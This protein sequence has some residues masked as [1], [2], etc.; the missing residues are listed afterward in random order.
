MPTERLKGE[1]MTGKGIDHLYATIARPAPHKA[2]IRSRN[3]PLVLA[4]SLLYLNK[5]KAYKSNLD[6]HLYAF[7]R[8]FINRNYR[9]ALIIDESFILF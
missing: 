7:G 6:Q 1:E 2:I 3:S 5:K 9:M 8:Y 4:R